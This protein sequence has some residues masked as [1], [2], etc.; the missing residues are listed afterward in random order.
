[1]NRKVRIL[2]HV[3]LVL[4]VLGLGFAGFYKLK[5]GRE[6]LG[7]QSPEISLP[8]VRA[9][10]VKIRDMEMTLSGEG[11]VYPLAETQITPQVSGNVVH[12]SDEMVNGGT[13]QKGEL[14]LAIAEADYEIAVTL[15]RAGLREAENK[16]ENAREESRAAI[17]EWESLHPDKEPPPLVAKKPQLE[18]A[19]ANL[20][21]Q[22]ANL[23]KARLNL[24]RTKI[25]APFNCRVSAEQVDIGQY[26]SPGQA[27]ATLYATDAVEIVVPMEGKSL[28]WF[29]VPGF[30]TDGKKGASVTVTAHVAGDRHSWKG[31]AVRV[32]GKIDQ[33]TRMVNV[34]IRVP[35][36]YAKTPPLAPGQFAEVEITGRTIE[37]AAVIPI[38]AIHEENTVWAVNTVYDRLHIRRVDIAY[39]DEQ[40]AVVQS[41][42][43]DGEYVAVSA[44]KGVTEG[45]KVKYVDITAGDDS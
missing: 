15:A 19:K 45:M 32:Q 33:N 7:R 6:A 17:S 10:P 20:E 21:A 8:L 23:E 18:A 37:D 5:S 4:V 27:L 25:H 9:V 41:G 30:T 12:V 42:L 35:D 22:Q 31:E 43:K 11:T 16:Y 3:L 26:V 36:P 13:F 2:I 24:R 44:I 28:K 1:M 39:M 40:G 14:L 34:V 29:D 38:N